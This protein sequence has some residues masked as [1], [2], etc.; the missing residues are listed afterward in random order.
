MN[1]L[2]NYMMWDG[3][4]C[5]EVDGGRGG[6]MVRRRVVVV[7]EALRRSPL[8]RKLC[9]QHQLFPVGLDLI[10]VLNDRVVHHFTCEKK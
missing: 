5:G 3:G 9:S 4:W 10:L 2:R 1:L 7:R 8:I 6:S